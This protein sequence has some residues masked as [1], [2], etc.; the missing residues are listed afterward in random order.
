[1]SEIMHD[2]ITV[3]GQEVIASGHVSLGNI[4]RYFETLRWGMLTRPGA[5]L[6]GKVERLVAR[7]Q[8]IDCASPPA[9]PCTLDVETWLARVGRSSLDFGHRVRREED[10]AEVA[11]GRIT[12][13]HV[14]DSGPIPLDPALADAV[15]ERAAPDHPRDIVEAGGDVF[16]RRWVVRHSDQDRFLHM[17]QAGYFD[18]VEDTLQLAALRGHAAGSGLTP[19]S[20]SVS[21]DREVHAGTELEMRLW[22]VSETDRVLELFAVGDE[23]PIS[24]LRATVR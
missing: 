15:V 7:A 14:N 21:Y 22:K 13:V 10:G 17:N 11:R 5:L 9:H 16:S 3:R 12:I 18:A 1:M 2:K 24:R 19:R 23:T 6:E 20:I 8:T 4:V